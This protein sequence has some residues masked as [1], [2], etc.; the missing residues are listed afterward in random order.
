MERGRESGIERMRE[1][2]REK[3]KTLK[4]ERLLNTRKAERERERE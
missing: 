3:K 1:G 4:R 2:E